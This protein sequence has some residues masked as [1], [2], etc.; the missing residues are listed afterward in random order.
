[1]VIGTLDHRRKITFRER[2]RTRQRDRDRLTEK[3]RET[4]RERGRERERERDHEH[5][6]KNTTLYFMGALRS[7]FIPILRA[8][9]NILGAERQSPL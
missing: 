7:P 9:K 4:E 2:E 8:I 6:K 3:E 1:M 5:R